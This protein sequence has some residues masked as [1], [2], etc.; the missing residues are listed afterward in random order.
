MKAMKYVGLGLIAASALCF[1]TPVGAEEPAESGSSRSTHINVEV[2]D[3]VSY[4][5]LI[6]VPPIYNFSTTLDGHG[7]YGSISAVD[8]NTS[9]PSDGLGE[10]TVAK[11][12]TTQSKWQV[13]AKMTIL[14]VYREGDNPRE[15]ATI[16]QFKYVSKSGEGLIGTSQSFE[17]GTGKYQGYLFNDGVFHEKNEVEGEDDITTGLL[18]KSVDEFELSFTAKDLRVGDELKG[19]L[20]YSVETVPA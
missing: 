7:Q 20:V 5:E 18:S 15:N 9:D 1:T 17:E 2:K 8:G 11:G 6:S 4:F 14:G 3:D 12:Y 10:V 19:S 13:R 16:T